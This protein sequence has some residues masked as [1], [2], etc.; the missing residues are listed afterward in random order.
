MLCPNLQLGALECTGLVGLNES[1]VD[2]DISDLTKNTWLANVVSHEA[3]HHWFGNLVSFQFWDD[4]WL[5]ESFADFMSL[6]ALSKITIET[7][8]M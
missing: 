3:A 7:R 1:F 6:L 4:L 5:K 2:D 8:K